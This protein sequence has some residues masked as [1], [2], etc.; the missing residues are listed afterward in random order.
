LMV[1]RSFE[2]SLK[3]KPDPFPGDRFN[4]NCSKIQFF[5]F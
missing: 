1:I 2:L 5:G 4:P 3:V